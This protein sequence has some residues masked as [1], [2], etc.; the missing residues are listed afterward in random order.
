MAASE[1]GPPSRPPSFEPLRPATRRWRTIVFLVG[2]LLWLASLMAVAVALRR[3]QAIEFALAVLIPT[4]T[5]RLREEE[6][7]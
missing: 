4:R 1:A 6:S 2:P 5:R 3:V 7:A